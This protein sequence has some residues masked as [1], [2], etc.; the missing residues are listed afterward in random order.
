MKEYPIEIRNG[1]VWRIWVHPSG[2][3]QIVDHKGRQRHISSD[4]VATAQHLAMKLAKVP[5]LD[6]HS[7]DEALR[8]GAQQWIEAM[9]QSNYAHKVRLSN[10]KVLILEERCD[11]R[12]GETLHIAAQDGDN[13]DVDA[14]ICTL[15][16]DGV[17]VM[18]NSCGGLKNL[19]D[20]LRPRV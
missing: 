1:E 4:H 5:L 16:L 2:Q 6:D 15:M 18:H 14:Y 7:A 19:L 13:D 20:G 10:G 17:L 3:C 9:G 8:Q 11:Q 12:D